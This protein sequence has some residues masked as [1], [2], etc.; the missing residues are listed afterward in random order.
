MH[1]IGTHRLMDAQVPEVAEVF[2]V[3]IL[4]CCLLGVASLLIS[5]LS[6]SA[7]ALYIRILCLVCISSG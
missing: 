4:C 1:L 6:F 2:T 3:E 5:S 7:G